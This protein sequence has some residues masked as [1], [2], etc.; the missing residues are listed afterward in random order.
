MALGDVAG[1]GQHA[2]DT[3]YRQWPGRQLAQAY[4][5]VAAADVAAEIT[6]EAVFFQHLQQAP[7]F[8]EIDPDAQVQ[9]GVIQRGM[10]VEAGQAAE[11]FVDLKQQAIT[12]ARQQ[13]TVRGSM[14]GLGELFFG[15]LQL[16]LGF[17]ELADI[18]H[19][20]NQGRCV[21]ELKG[22]CRDQTGEQLAVAAPE[23]RF[24]VTYAA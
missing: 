7:T 23:Q 17:L 4:L 2:V 5:A 13:Q 8:V 9:R 22:L 15:G 14:E 20:H 1:D 10:A 11:T 18:A 3:G 24:Q 16:L 6:D 12:L 19:G 21:V